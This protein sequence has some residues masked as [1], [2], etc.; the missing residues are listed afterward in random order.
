MILIAPYLLIQDVQHGGREGRHDPI[1]TPYTYVCRYRY[2]YTHIYTYIHTLLCIDLGRRIES[3]ALQ[4]S[5]IRGRQNRQMLVK[6]NDVEYSATT[7]SC[8]VHQQS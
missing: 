4:V 3:W 2:R 5:K 6:G 7:G 1:R 8:M